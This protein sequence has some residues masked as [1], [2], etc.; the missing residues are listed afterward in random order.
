MTKN[1]ITDNTNNNTNTNNKKRS[2]ACLNCRKA[3]V[4]CLKS[5][6]SELNLTT[7]PCNRCVLHGLECVYEYKVK[8][9]TSAFKKRQ[10][11]ETLPS[12]NSIIT[13]SLPAPLKS[14][15]LSQPIEQSQSQSQLQPQLQPQS[16]K[17]KSSIEQRLDGLGDQLVS[18]IDKINSTTNTNDSQLSVKKSKINDLGQS[19]LK[20]SSNINENTNTNTNTNSNSNINIS[21]ISNPNPNPNN[22]DSTSTSK[23]STDY[24]KD[25]LFP[26]YKNAKQFFVFF[27]QKI[28]PQLF[29]FDISKYSFDLIWNSCPLLV[30]TISCIASIHHPNLNHLSSSLEL[31]IYKISNKLLYSYPNNH[32][33]AF[34]T[35]IALVLCGFWFKNN[36]LFTGLAL[37]IANSFNLLKSNKFKNISKF[38]RLKLWYLLYILDSQQSLVFNT[39]TLFN[40]DD[41]TILNSKKLLSLKE[42]EQIE[43]KEIEESNDIP[44]PMDIRLL[45]QL[46]YHHAINAAFS[47][48]GWDLLSPNKFG[49]PFKTNLQLDKWMVQWTILLNPFKNI[50]IWS[51]KSTLIYYNF[52]KMYINSFSIRN[53]DNL[54]NLP[55]LNDL[56]N[57]ESD[58]AL[59]NEIGN[60]ENKTAN[61]IDN[62][63]NKDN[64]EEDDD[65]EEEEGEDYD[66]DHSSSN[67]E[68]DI[69]TLSPQ[70]SHRVALSAAETILN[71]VVN[72][73][74]IL[75]NL[76]YVPVHI[77]IMLYYAALLILKHN[78]N[79]GTS[80]QNESVFTESIKF[81]NLVKKL[82]VSILNNKPIDKHFSL[83]LINQLDNLII[84]KINS[85]KPVFNSTSQLQILTNIQNTNNHDLHQSDGSDD[86]KQRISAWPGVDA[87]HPFKKVD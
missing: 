82:K 63:D 55:S 83:N 50:P 68:D 51:S 28:S 8:T 45:S 14:D 58:D 11:D 33:Q 7:T 40:N 54:N 13:P 73:H 57:E 87:S 26:S 65:E 9:Y 4:K 20:L 41:S 32:L 67:D 25:P 39:N 69:A 49:L 61:H 76:K 60:D 80:N 29:G 37:Q 35:I 53:F 70:Q 84:D 81:I 47:G 46:E 6:T 5:S 72:D 30:V 43:E 64:E 2:K 38:D 59:E 77:H 66:E 15:S 31:L 62:K 71:L 52:A 78:T 19:L 27:N 85:L 48:N 74:D 34:N 42:K 75:N 24:Q 79:I 17:W 12:S 86:G 18:L 1:D 22:T 23:T 44:L 3:K 36:Q 21:S 56:S 10:L 16:S